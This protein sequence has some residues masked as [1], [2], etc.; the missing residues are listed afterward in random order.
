MMKLKKISALVLA[1]A[2]VLTTS[3]TTFAATL[4]GGEIGGTTFPKDSPGTQDKNI[5]IKKE[6]TV[7]NVDVE[8][9]KAPNISYTY[10]VTAGP[11][12]VKITDATSDHAN[13][14]AVSALTKAGVLTGLKVNNTEG[15]TGTIAW[16]SAE[17]V[18]ASTA[19]VSNYK[20]LNIDFSSVNFGAPG[21]Y[22][23]TITEALTNS[24]TYASSGVT[25][26]DNTT[27]PHTRYLDVY[28]RAN[29]TAADLDKNENGD[30][31]EATDWDIYGY[32]CVL[33]SEEIT[34]D[35]DTTTKGAVKT[36][37]F[38]AGT[39]DSKDYSADSYYTFNV[40]VSK[41]VTNDNYA[42]A[43][44]SFPFTVIFT[45]NAVTQNVD[46]KSTVTG[47]A[48]GFTD[49]E[50]SP[51]KKDTDTSNIKGVVAIKDSSSVKYIGIPNGTSVEVYETND[52]TG[53]TYQVSTTVDGTTSTTD[54][55][56]DPA[57]ISGSAPTDAVAQASQKAEYQ[58]TKA[59]I[60]TIANADDDV[61]HTVAVD[62]NMQMISPTG[63]V[64]RVAP[65]LLMLAAGIALVVILMAKRRKHTDEE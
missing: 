23:Y 3:T 6:L 56:V 46:I 11:A 5:N 15:T 29:P 12:N 9:I 18:N 37:G 34:P 41:T 35:G 43:T 49:P 4:D 25:E 31:D 24:Y 13:D 39:N 61:S 47:T 44:H 54:D 55:T 65:Y 7:F 26:T 38:V 10:T 14:T 8:S 50:N 40:T 63:V 32:V 27:N 53:V 59:N 28:V 45:N 42:K 36:N 33:E 30:L 52:L 16:T 48:S 62:N 17:E 22:R 21:V 57:V 64:L 58:S 1:L 60:T 51:L 20:N 19:G 2:L